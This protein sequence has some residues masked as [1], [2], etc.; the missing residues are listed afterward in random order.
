MFATAHVC[1]YISFSQ[2]PPPPPPQCRHNRQVMYILCL[3]IRLFTFLIQNYW[4][5]FGDSG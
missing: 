5:G 3:P 4:I 1:V 2:P